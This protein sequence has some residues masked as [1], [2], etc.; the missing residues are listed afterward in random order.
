M[1]YLGITEDKRVRATLNGIPVK[2]YQYTQSSK[3]I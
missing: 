2:V 1:E 3:I